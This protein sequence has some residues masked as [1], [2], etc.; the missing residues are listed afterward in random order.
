MATKENAR[1]KRK[2]SIRK[3]LSGSV[4]RPRLSVY[5]STQHIYV[6][7]ID[8]SDAAKSNTLVASSTLD[9]SLVEALKGMKKRDQAKQVGKKIAE[10][11]KGAKISKVVFDR[12]CFNYTGRIKL[13]ADAARE[14]GLNF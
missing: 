10:L 14:G 13:L 5:R 2:Q 8:D 6:Q 9:P 4:E 11:A 12:N 1:L 7:V 3:R